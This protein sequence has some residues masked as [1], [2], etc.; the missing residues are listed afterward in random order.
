MSSNIVT[1]RVLLQWTA[2]PDHQRHYFII[3]LVLAIVTFVFLMVNIFMGESGFPEARPYFIAAFGLCAIATVGIAQYLKASFQ[4]IQ[5]LDGLRSLIVRERFTTDEYSWPMNYTVSYYMN[6]IFTGRTVRDCPILLLDLE[7]EAGECLVRLR[8]E[9]G[10]LYQPPFGW[11]KLDKRSGET[12]P[13][14]AKSYSSF[15][16]R[17]LNLEKLKEQL[18]RLAVAFPRDRE[19]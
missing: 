2:I 10:Y 6:P 16:L 3:A 19:S 7:N 9:L 4:I 15:G 18:D 12:I 14:G 5:R 13:P 8:E 17:L 1:E 11:R